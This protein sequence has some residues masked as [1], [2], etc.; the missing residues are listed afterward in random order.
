MRIGIVTFHGADNYGS[1][2]QAY[3]LSRYLRTLGHEVDIIDYYFEHDYRQYQLFRTYRYKAHAASFVSDLISFAPHYKRKKNFAAFR[4]QFLPM[5]PHRAST[6]DELREL[7][8]QYDGFICGSDQIWNL[9]CTDGVNAAFFLEFAEKGKRKV[10]YAP[11]MGSYALREEDKSAIGQSLD[12]F[13]A[14]SVRESSMISLLA[15][16]VPQQKIAHVL[17]PTLLLTADDYRRG[18]TVTEKNQHYIF[19]YILGGTKAYAGIIEQA[20]RLAQQRNAALFYIFDNNNGIFRL[21]GRDYS[22][23]SPR[24]FVSLIASADYVLT[25]SFHATVFSILFHKDFTA[26][27]RGNSSG[28]ITEL[29]D[30]LGLGERFYTKQGG[31]LGHMDS[32]EAADRA[33]DKQREVSRQFIRDALN[34]RMVRE[35]EWMNRED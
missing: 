26:F 33:L 18:L 21:H 7:N 2:L 10:A 23:C 13:D 25:N 11:S 30:S 35:T 5:T 20:K 15:E 24:E 19:L 31:L 4:K 29:L 9:D 8:D 6:I 22:G 14:I 27:S 1:V 32:Y 17:D 3:A 12:S 16:L 28:R 34:G